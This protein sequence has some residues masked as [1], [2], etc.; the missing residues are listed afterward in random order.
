MPGKYNPVELEIA[1]SR[2]ASIADEADANVART[3][4]SSII[5]DSH[6]YSCGI[7]D[8]RGNLLSQPATVAPAHLGGMTAAMKV[9]ETYFP[10][11]TLREG[12]AIVTNDPWIVSGHLPDIMVTKPVFHHSRLVAFAGCVFHHQDIGGH[13]GTD[14]L[15]V[16]E[17]GLQIPPSMLFRGG[18]E[19][20]D[21]IRIIAQN[22][23]VPD[24]VV[25]DLRSQVS[26]LHFTGSRICAFL[27]DLKIDELDSLADEIYD[28]TESAVARGIGEIPD[29]VYESEKLVELGDDDRNVRLKLRLAVRGETLTAD[30][31]GTD[32]QVEQG[33]NCVFNYTTAYL[34]FG[35]MSLVA[36]FLPS[37]AGAVRPLKVQA[38][39]GSVL[40]ARRP[41]SVVG[42][43]AVGQFIPELVYSALASVV[44]DRVIAESGSL[45][46]WWL[47]LS[48]RR[49]GGAPF[50]VGP[51]FSGG[52]GARSS[53]DGVSALTFPTN[54]MNNPVEMMETESPL[55]VEKRELLPDSAGAGRF[56]GGY[57]QEFIVRV[58]EGE[59]APEG[60]VINFLVAGRMVSGPEGLH[61]GAG[62]PAASVSVNG[63]D[64][65]WG[66]P[67]L[68]KAGDRICYR[69]AGGG[70]YGDPHLRDHELVR[71]EMRDG[72]VSPQQARDVY[73]LPDDSD[74]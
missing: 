29:G 46:L 38:P 30:F 3:A 20:E 7:Y 18:R 23:R 59:H 14:T 44:P 5:R 34:L 56:R 11:D 42:R 69:T 36:P 22:V 37:N 58:P 1:W 71:Q 43:T 68:L 21:L 73:G 9:L 15:E 32:P 25:N 63:T 31:E 47:T 40:N 64:I 10:F 24:L 62:A 54:I 2:V 66:R 33:I 4:F 50:V 57:G 53:L 55:L 39:E 60:P 41:A 65:G 16:Y 72:L 49:R 45:P 61:G 28:R 19:N 51:M 26:S 52:L 67:Y 70:G 74:D 8:S 13:L 12:D 17:E 35:V 27:D 6:D 48:G